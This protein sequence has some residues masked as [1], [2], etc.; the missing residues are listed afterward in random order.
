[1]Q[2]AAAALLLLASACSDKSSSSSS[3]S[4]GSSGGTS[5]SSSSSDTPKHDSAPKDETVKS[6]RGY[7]ESKQPESESAEGTEI[8]ADK[9]YQAGERLKVSSLGFSYVVPEKQIS[10]YATGGSAINIGEVGGNMLTLIVARTGITEAEARDMLSQPYDIGGGDMLKLTSEISK[11]GDRLSAAMASAKV[12]GHVQ[13][14]IGKSTGVAIM[15][16]GLAGSEA[17][18]KEFSGKLADSVKFA[19]PAGEKQRKEHEAG[20]MGKRVKVF[21]FKAAKDYSWSS[22]TNKD[23]HFGSDHTYQYIYKNTNS[24][25]GAAGGYAS[26]ND[27]NHA[28]TWRIELTLNMP[29]LI[30]RTNQGRIYTHTLSVVKGY[31]N[32]DGEEASI[33]ASDR[34]K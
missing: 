32:V 28:G 34:K 13:M 22:E 7:S 6:E 25:S 29:V 3:S 31:L 4:S 21:K 20:L 12:T 27:S 23:W 33:G 5:S 18:C 16:I 9:Q 19:T 15:S 17:A 30:L 8:V 2:F 11:D 26:D 14:L 1:M 24:S 10:V